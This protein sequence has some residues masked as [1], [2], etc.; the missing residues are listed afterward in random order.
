VFRDGFTPAARASAA[1]DRRPEAGPARRNLLDAEQAVTQPVPVGDRAQRTQ[2]RRPARKQSVQPGMAAKRSSRDD[3]T[4]GRPGS[5]RIENRFRVRRSFRL[6]SG[7]ISLTSRASSSRAPRS[8]AVRVYVILRDWR[9]RHASSGVRMWA[10]T[11]ERM[12]TLL[13]M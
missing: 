13:P 3:T 10:R 1:A 8:P 2:R 4:T 6:Y 7:C 11:R 5:R 9:R 12:S